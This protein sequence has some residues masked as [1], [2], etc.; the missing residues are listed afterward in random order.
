MKGITIGIVLIFIGAAIA[1]SV[2]ISAVDASNTPITIEVTLRA[3]SRSEDSSITVPLTPQQIQD[4]RT[5]FD[6]LHTR[7]STAGSLEETWR[8]FNDTI[9]SLSRYNLLPA[10]MSTKQVKYLVRSACLD[11]LRGSS[12]QRIYLKTQKNTNDGGIQN[13]FCSIAGNTSNIH[14]LKPVGKLSLDTF[15]VYAHSTGNVILALLSYPIWVVFYALNLISQPLLQ[16]DGRHLGVSIYFGNYHYA[17]Y[18]DWLSPAEGWVSTDG[19]NGIQNITGSFWGQKM[20]S[21]WQPEDDWYMNY[22]WRGCLG[23]TGLILSM[24]QDSA[25]YLGSALSINVGPNRP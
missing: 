1:P 19:I 23:F 22:S 16:R 4:V 21:C 3:Y 2:T 24:G 14:F 11:Q 6:A 10:G 7:L 17:P 25:Y 12:I 15:E 18:P 13:S 20:T 8:I 9:D 5:L